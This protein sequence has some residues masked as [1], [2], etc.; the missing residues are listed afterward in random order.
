MA[1]KCMKRCSTSLS[2]KEMQIKATLR[3]HLTQLQ[4]PYSKAK[5]TNTSEDAA[6]QEPLYTVGAKAY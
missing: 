1:N 3:F 5:T 2:I 6:K 4:W